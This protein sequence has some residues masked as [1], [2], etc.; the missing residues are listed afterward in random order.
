MALPSQVKCDSCGGDI[1]RS[2]GYMLISEQV[3]SSPAFWRFHYERNKQ[4]YADAGVNSFDNFC[5]AQGSLVESCFKFADDPSVWLVCTDCVALFDIDRKISSGHAKYWWDN[6]GEFSLKGEPADHW[7]I[8]TGDGR[9]Y[10]RWD[11]S[12]KEVFN[13]LE[14]PPEKRKKWWQFW[15]GLK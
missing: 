2:C 5:S 12:G 3:V 8:N 4:V 9:R 10:F 13:P 14:C 15:K 6:N 11:G 1:P 7:T